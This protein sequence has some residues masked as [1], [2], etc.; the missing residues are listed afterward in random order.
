MKRP[1]LI[2]AIFLTLGI[3]TAYYFRIPSTAI[4][5]L[6][7][8][9]L[10]SC[11]V[12]IL[13]GRRV[14]ALFLLLFY[15]LSILHSNYF[16][17]SLIEGYAN[18][19]VD[20]IGTIHREY[21]RDGYRT[22]DV[23]VHSING[24]SV[25]EKIRTNIYEDVNF[26]PGSRI[27]LEGQLYGPTG[28]TNPMLFDHRQYLLTKNIKYMFRTEDYS[29]RYDNDSIGFVY[30]AQNAFRDR[31]D[32]VYDNG[33]SKRNAGFMKALLGGEKDSLDQNEYDMY[34]EMGLAHILA[35]SGLHIGILAGFM[36]FVMSRVG[37]KRNL[38]IPISLVLVWMFSL[39]VGFPESAL[40]ASV[41]LTFVLTSKVL[42]RPYD[43]VNILAASYIICLLI[44]PFWLFSIG[45][46]L[47]YG[48]TLSLAV[49]SPWIMKRIYP[50]KGKLAMSM[51]AVVAVNMGILPLQSYYFNQLPLLALVSNLLIVPV[52]TINLILGFLVIGITS[53]TP[54]LEWLLNVQSHI[55]DLLSLLPIEALGLAS[56]GPYQM[57]VYYFVLTIALK[58]NSIHYVG[59]GIRKA[60]VVYLMLLSAMGL[61]NVF[62]PP[63][64]EIHFIDVGQG[65]AALIRVEGREYLIDTGGAIFGGYDPGEAITLPYL[66]KLGVRR[67]E[68]V[69]ISHF[70]EDH[71]K[72]LFPIMKEIGI[73]A[74]YVNRQIPDGNLQNTAKMLNIPVFLI[75]EGSRIDLNG[76]SIECIYSSGGSYTN[77]NNNSIVLLFKS[78]EVSTLFT[79]DIEEEVED[80]IRG[81]D[82]DILKVAHHGSKTSSSHDHISELL[83]D[84]SVISV[85]RDN[86]FGHPHESVLE[87]LKR[88]DSTIYRTDEAG[89]IKLI[90]NDG[91]VEVFPYY[92]P[93]YQEDPSKFL[94]DYGYRLSWIAVYCIL[95]YISVR[96]YVKMEENN[97]EIY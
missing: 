11:M 91:R 76:S 26:Y 42:H 36:L 59:I 51:A 15:M 22:Y 24:K 34:K 6:S 41:M 1:A 93:P 4:L 83:P 71:Y 44:N 19:D 32:K 46:Q 56:P 74:L 77:E 16:H 5:F 39:L 45:F 92:G 75:Q 63:K 28:N 50:L 86:S 31:L 43:P 96:T 69:F 47:S 73:D 95:S 81:Y 21:A 53:L 58:W 94:Y 10:I 70:H 33:L 30:E 13:S 49:V 66:R 52:A 68:G 65:D 35:I 79:G 88:S 62:I 17:E 25:R 61:L 2:P 48:A 78:H 38:A 55:I 14:G 57:V 82:V 37:L 27:E 3:L 84:I 29:I 80:E 85:G 20:I 90:L 67:L 23:V 60:M 7:L 40:R 8:L 97:Y 18:Q 72:G 54:I 89:L 87:T 12:F 64:T 9:L